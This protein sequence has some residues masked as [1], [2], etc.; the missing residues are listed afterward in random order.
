MAASSVPGTN[1]TNL[2]GLMKSVN[3]GGPEVTG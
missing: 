2:F 3:K 1:R